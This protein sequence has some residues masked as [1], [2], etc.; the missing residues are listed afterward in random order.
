MSPMVSLSTQWKNGMST[1]LQT[2]RTRGTDLRYQRN[3][4]VDEAGNFPTL[5]E[6]TIGTTITNTRNLRA[7]LRYSIKPRIFE[8]LQSNIDMDLTFQTSGNQQVE[9]PRIIAEPEPGEEPQEEI[10]RRDENTWSGQI[11]AQYRFSENFTG[12]LSFRHEQRKDKLRE[13]TNMTY[14][15]RVFGEIE[16][17]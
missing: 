7:N 2:N 8:S 3:V 16:F 13:L 17:N 10:I 11:G 14:E 15:F 9:R 12:G 5:E 6:R 1:T 4:Q